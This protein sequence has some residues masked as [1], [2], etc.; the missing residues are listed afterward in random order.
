MLAIGIFFVA[1]DSARHI[2]LHGLGWGIRNRQLIWL[3]WGVLFRAF[4]GCC[5]IAWEMVREFG[6]AFVGGGLLSYS[7]RQ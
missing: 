1:L 7:Q 5:Y 2:F 3:V 4:S 6:W